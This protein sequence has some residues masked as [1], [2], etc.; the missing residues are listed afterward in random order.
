MLDEEGNNNSGLKS[1]SQSVAA[2]AAAANLYDSTSSAS[3]ASSTSSLTAASSSG[4]YGQPIAPTSHLKQANSNSNAPILSSHLSGDSKQHLFDDSMM[5]SGNGA[6]QIGG[7]T[8][9]DK[10]DNDDEVSITFIIWLLNKQN[11]F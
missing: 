3:S 11:I 1:P 10:I 5:Y 4:S 6:A 8:K 9:L 2:A 7:P